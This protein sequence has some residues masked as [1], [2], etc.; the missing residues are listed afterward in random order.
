MAEI[1]EILTKLAESTDQGK[2]DWK[3]TV[4]EQ[5][6]M[7]AIGNLSVVIQWEIGSY[8]LLKILDSSGSEIDRPD[9]QTHSE[10]RDDLFELHEQAR[11]IALQVDRKLD[12]LLKTLETGA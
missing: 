11:R 9:G 3:P 2:I 6:F 8:P 1:S 10:S 5:A 7:A 4:N 12:E